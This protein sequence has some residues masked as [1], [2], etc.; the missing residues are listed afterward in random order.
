MFTCG[1]TNPFR[2]FEG[3]RSIGMGKL[4]EL[5]WDCA[6]GVE[7]RPIEYGRKERLVQ[8]SS[9]RVPKCVILPLSS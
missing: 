3:K 9:M 2:D 5:R 7:W 8:L 6:Q 1:L 4:E